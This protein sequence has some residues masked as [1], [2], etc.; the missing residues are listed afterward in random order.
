MDA[1]K[2][3][4]KF[5]EMLREE[6]AYIDVQL[7]KDTHQPERRLYTL[8]EKAA[9]VRVQTFLESYLRYGEIENL[10]GEE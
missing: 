2:L 3:I 10:V 5:R 4:D 1:Q 6:Q 8:G 9:L 7:E